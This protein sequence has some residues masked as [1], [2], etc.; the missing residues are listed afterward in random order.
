MRYI[1]YRLKEFTELVERDIA[2]RVQLWQGFRLLKKKLKVI[3]H[4]GNFDR[5]KKILIQDQLPP[6]LNERK[7]KLW[8]KF[9]EAKMSGQKVRWLGE[10]LIIDNETVEAPRDFIRPLWD[11][12]DQ[13]ISEVKFKNETPNQDHSGQYFHKIISQMLHQWKTLHHHFRLCLWTLVWQGLP[14]IP[15]AYRISSEGGAI[16]HC[17]DD[18]KWEAGRQNLKILRDTNIMDKLVVVSRWFGGQNIGPKRYIE[19]AGKEVCDYL[20]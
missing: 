14:T 1:L 13:R 8:P 6:E 5:S 12:I 4:I 2:T 20:I 3:K 19:A 16:E 17:E 18:G 15:Y 7:K 11:N 10:K 9:K